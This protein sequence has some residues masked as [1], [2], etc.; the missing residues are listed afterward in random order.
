M[1]KQY[2]KK[3]E[4][5]LHGAIAEW[6]GYKTEDKMKYLLGVRKDPDGHLIAGLVSKEQRHGCDLYH[7]SQYTTSGRPDRMKIR[8]LVSQY[9]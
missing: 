1:Q 3:L 5:V 9:A 4:S 2:Q 7:P 6:L 8:N